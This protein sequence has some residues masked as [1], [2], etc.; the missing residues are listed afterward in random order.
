V[1][2][3]RIGTPDDVAGAV[4]YLTGASLVTG[5]ILPVDGGYTVA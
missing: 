4:Q 1:P 5:T 2:A 3:G